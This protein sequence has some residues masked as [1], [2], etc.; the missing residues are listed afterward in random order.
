MN[1]EKVI[2]VAG[3][4]LRQVYLAEILTRKYKVYITGFDKNIVH[5]EKAILTDGLMS[6]P[7]RADYIILPL[8]VS[9]DGVMVN[10][11]FFKYSIPLDNLVNILTED[12]LVFGGKFSDSAK[13]LFESHGI[14]TVDYL[15]RE[16]LTVLNAVPT[17]EGAVQ[18]AM[19]EVPTTIFGQKILITGFGRITKVLVKI[20]NG[21]GA[22]V[23][24]TARKYAD[25]AWAEIF[26][27]KGIHISQA[28]ESLGEYDIIFNTV[29]AVL[30]GEKQLS[31]LKKN[32]LV[33]DL[34]SKPGGADCGSD[35][36]PAIFPQRAHI[37]VLQKPFSLSAEDSNEHYGT[38]SS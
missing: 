32:C 19:E 16:E 17:A 33:I 11:P 22:D 12:G 31:L 4:D 6:I 1:R 5:S 18:I 37:Y 34:A 38:L 9:H 35:K 27:C 15:E 30:L 26:G 8:P 28:E 29:P 7:E 23:S 36:V 14:E 3:G 24:I 2:L 25:L 10:T 13:D 21:M 20:L